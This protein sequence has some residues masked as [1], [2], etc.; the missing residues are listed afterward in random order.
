M[1]GHDIHRSA[2]RLR[3]RL[4]YSLPEGLVDQPFEVLIGY[5]CITAGIP[6]LLGGASATPN[7]IDDL[8][9]PL[10]V[11]GWALA[12]LVGG[13]LTA[14]GKTVGWY[15][16]ERAG[17]ALLAGG[18]VVYGIALVGQFAA[19]AY[20]AAGT[21]FVTTAFCVVRYW[22]VGHTMDVTKASNQ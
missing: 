19:Q 4:L 9:P 15:R 11:T 12:L 21:Y 1:T 16:F 18:T 14:T 13:L 10:L 5:L 7:S 20:L 2:T 22:S 8:L 17:L 6:L 3:D